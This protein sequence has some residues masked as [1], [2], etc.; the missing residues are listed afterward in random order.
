MNARGFLLVAATAAVL[1]CGEATSPSRNDLYEWRR[2]EGADTLSFHWPEDRLPVRIWVQDSLDIPSRVQE[3]VAAWKAAYLY[4]E[5]D[6][7]LVADSTTAD[8][9][10]LVTAALPAGVNT[11][12]RLRTILLG[13]EGETVVDTAATRFQLRLPMRVRMTPRFN[14]ATTDL[15]ECFRVLATH[16]LGHSL[17]IFDH[18]PDDGDI[19]YDDPTVSGLSTRDVNTAQALAHYPANMTPVR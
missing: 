14:P 8:V 15:T 12:A 13:C 5:Y 1:S 7:V 2:V 4:G 16:E 17:G 19:M 10:V 3:G 18:S 9:V 11:V 6:A